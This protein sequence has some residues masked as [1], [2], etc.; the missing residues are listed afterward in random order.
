[1][2]QLHCHA[3]IE[4]G[5]SMRSGARHLV[6]LIINGRIM[7]NFGIFTFWPQNERNGKA[8]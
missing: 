4:R 6:Q 1:M 3:L 8:L 7:I 5:S 2:L